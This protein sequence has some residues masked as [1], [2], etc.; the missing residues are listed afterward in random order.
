MY[1]F[2]GIIGFVLL[3]DQGELKVTVNLQLYTSMY[4]DGFLFLLVN[5]EE[6]RNVTETIFYNKHFVL[7]C[8]SGPLFII[9]VYIKTS[10]V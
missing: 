7:S 4:G 3:L 10:T 6:S 2:S 1:H 8:R 9:P 5:I